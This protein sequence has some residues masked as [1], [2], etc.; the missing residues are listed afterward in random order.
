MVDFSFLVM[1]EMSS[2]HENRKTQL[3]GP[4]AQQER[5]EGPGVVIHLTSGEHKECLM[6]LQNITVEIKPVT[7]VYQA[8]LLS[9]RILPHIYL[10]F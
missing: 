9:S 3:S 2:S 5:V 10:F 6:D 7:P 4:A 1:T 8:L